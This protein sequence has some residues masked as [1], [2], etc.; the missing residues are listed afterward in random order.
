MDTTESFNHCESSLNNTET[1][2]VNCNMCH[3]H[4]H[5]YIVHCEF[6]KNKNSLTLQLINSNNPPTYY[7]YLIIPT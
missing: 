6:F 7:S 5:M 2:L 1:D 4:V 3:T